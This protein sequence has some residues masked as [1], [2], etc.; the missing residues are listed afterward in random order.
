MVPDYS[1]KE[2]TNR[3]SANNGSWTTNK[4]GFIVFKF[5]FSQYSTIPG[6]LY[7]HI[8]NKEQWATFTRPEQGWAEVGTLPVKAGDTIVLKHDNIGVNPIITCYFIPPVTI[9]EGN[10]NISTTETLTGRYY[11]GKPTYTR[12]FKGTITAAINTTNNTTFTIAGMTGL[13]GYGGEVD[14]GN[15]NVIGASYSE[16]GYYS[17]VFYAKA[18][19]V[20]TL[21]STIGS[22]RTNAPYS[23]WVEYTKT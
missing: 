8:N 21:R 19:G 6:G 22:A 1:N 11:D 15:G 17:G 18:T 2:T 7:C 20:L 12:I 10:N 4:S 13:V 5:A 9:Q 3:I 14:V 16:Q 23:F